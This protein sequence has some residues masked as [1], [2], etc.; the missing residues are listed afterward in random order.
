LDEIQSQMD[1]ILKYRFLPLKQQR[2]KSIL[3]SAG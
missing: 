2:C 1:G 3:A